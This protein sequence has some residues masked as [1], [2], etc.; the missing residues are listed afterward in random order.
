MNLSLRNRVAI[1]FIL[2]AVIVVILGLTVFHFLHV[3]NQEIEVTSQDSNQ[4]AV[5]SDEIRISAVN[6]LKYE[7][8]LVQ[9]EN[10]LGQMMFHDSTKKKMIDL[11]DTLTGQLKT[12]D[13]FHSD[14]AINKTIATMS[15]YV[16]SLGLILKKSLTLEKD[17]ALTSGIGDLAN[18]ILDTLSEYL[19]A[20]YEI[21]AK[22]DFKMQTI[23]RRTKKNMMYTLIISFVGTMLL[24][25][26]V[27]GKIALPFKKI[28][29]AIRELQ[30]CNFD[31]SIFYNQD[32]EIGEMASEMNKMIVSFK[33][34]EELRTNRIL[35]EGRKFDALANMVHK[36]I[37]VANAH[38][39][40]IYMN[41]Q[42]YSLLQLE[43]DEVI[44]KNMK[45]TRIPSSIIE[46]YELA[47]KRRSKIE[48]A[49][50][51]IYRH[52]VE[53][54]DEDL[55]D[56]GQEVLFKGYANVIPIRGK[57]SS[58]DYYL[59]VMSEDVFA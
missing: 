43:S 28:N 12:L 13:H 58:L 16:D 18:K 38:G 26:V 59:M 46:S 24:F 20:Q 35:L 11:C 45:D 49:E 21:N 39:E 19:K 23:I 37:L 54:D 8:S 47:I 2:S 50:I 55:D 29:D 15:G 4:I 9:N 42:L 31:V 27:P 3:L 36:H 53:E 33:K 17:M 41:N 57:E 5:L 10:N 52:N 48:N 14:P 30:E 40:L 44:F 7:H 22:R 1:S 56:I 25:L 32:D 34:F 51:M 6:I